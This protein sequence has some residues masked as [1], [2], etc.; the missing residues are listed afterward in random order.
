MTL[1]TAGLKAAGPVLQQNL[2]SVTLRRSKDKMTCGLSSATNSGTMRSHKDTA[3][4]LETYAKV[5][6][7]WLPTATGVAQSGTWP[8]SS[9]LET[10]F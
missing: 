3:K 1:A 8:L 6:L 5:E 4:F 9:H 7:I 10:S 2:D